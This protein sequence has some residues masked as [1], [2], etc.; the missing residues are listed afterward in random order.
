MQMW[1]FTALER[2]KRFEL[3]WW[4]LWLACFLFLFQCHHRSRSWKDFSNA[5][6]SR[7]QNCTWYSTQLWNFGIGFGK[8]SLSPYQW[9][10]CCSGMPL[11]H[12]T[13]FNLSLLKWI[14]TFVPYRHWCLDLKM[15]SPCCLLSYYEMRVCFKKWR[16]LLVCP[17]A[18]LL[19]W[20]ALDYFSRWRNMSILRQCL[21][22]GR[23]GGD[24]GGG[25]QWVCQKNSA[26]NREARHHHEAVILS[27]QL[28]PTNT[29]LN[30][31]TRTYYQHQQI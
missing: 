21:Y 6:F 9:E 19:R 20:T 13:P 10:G 17:A 26:E 28:L 24:P 29:F 12:S 2:V 30:T 15:H 22:G 4:W 23:A 1:A 31:H 7:F 5:E 8:D 11:H 14:F 25:G 27:H 18:F 16:I 3:V